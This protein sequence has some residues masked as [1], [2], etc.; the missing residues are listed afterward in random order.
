MKIIQ[1]QIGIAIAIDETRRRWGSKLT[2]RLDLPLPI[3]WFDWH[4]G[5]GAASGG[6]VASA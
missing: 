6:Y 5:F 4:Q 2:Q 1:I 3:R